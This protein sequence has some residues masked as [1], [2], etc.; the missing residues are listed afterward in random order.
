MSVAIART[1]MLVYSTIEE[2]VSVCVSVCVSRFS[3]HSLEQVRG[4]NLEGICSVMHTFIVPESE[5]S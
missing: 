3:S 1:G 4:C 2:H 5:Y